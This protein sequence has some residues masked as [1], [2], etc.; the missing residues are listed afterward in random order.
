MAT[1]YPQNLPPSARVLPKVSVAMVT[2]NQ[3]KYIAQ[4]VESVMMQQTSF[5]YEVVVGE[6]CSTDNT[7][8]ILLDLKQKYPEKLKLLLHDRNLG[9]FGNGNFRAALQAC[10]GQ[11]LAILEGDDYWTSPHKLQKQVDALDR[12]PD[13]SICTHRVMV[14]FED[15]SQPSYL[16]PR[17]D[18]KPVSTLDDLARASFVGTSA[19]VYRNY[20]VERQYPDW[21]FQVDTGDYALALFYAQFG[22]IGFIDEVMCAYRKHREAVWSALDSVTQR[23][24]L[25]RSLRIIASHMEW[26]YRRKLE[27][28]AAQ[29]LLQIA[30]TH[31]ENGSVS[32]ARKVIRSLL[33]A[34]Y[35][36]PGVPKR[37]LSRIALM[38][39][40]PWIFPIVRRVK[41]LAMP[42]KPQGKA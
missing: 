7:R 4:A 33:P 29:A 14:F 11:Y 5:D 15:A 30:K 21:L 6:D 41:W 38:A 34:A 12:N 13:W 19:A 39:H 31:L 1:T 26:R 32:E 28:Q 3:E 16:G 22:K 37:R 27:S 23:T 25:A 10:R 9:G 40:A 24:R 18:P 2:Y 8:Q 17:F 20:T 42:L 35:F 36:L